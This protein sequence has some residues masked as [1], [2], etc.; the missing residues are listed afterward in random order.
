M[1]LRPESLADRAAVFS[2]TQL[3]FRGHPHSDG[4]EPRIIDALRDAKALTISIVA[5]LQGQIVGHAAFSP[6][7]WCEQA[8]WFGLGP[9]SVH[10]DLQGRGI[11]Q[12]LIETGLEQLR[13]IGASGCVVLGDP[14]YY[15]RFGFTQ[16]ERFT[17][18]GP[19]P[20][21]FTVLIWQEASSGLS[22]KVSYHQP[23]TDNAAYF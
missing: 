22:S 18:P 2:L 20:E 13:T 8:G 23:S 17:Y 12:K 1:I 11:G 16:D 3:A 10:P 7:K 21:Y 14:A 19:P 4:S 15:S 9:V 5:D 6:V